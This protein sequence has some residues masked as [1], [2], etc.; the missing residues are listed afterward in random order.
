MDLKTIGLGLLSFSFVILYLIQKYDYSKLNERLYKQDARYQGELK[1]LEDTHQL[2]IKEIEDEKKIIVKEVAVK[3]KEMIETVT[4]KLESAEYYQK[5]NDENRTYHLEKLKGLKDQV[6]QCFEI[7]IKEAD[8]ALSKNDYRIAELF[9]RACL[10]LRPE[11]EALL[12][13][14][15]RIEVFRVVNKYGMAFLN[16]PKGEFKMGSIASEKMRSTDEALHKVT[17]TTNFYMMETEVTQ[18]QW[19]AVMNSPKGELR[20]LKDIVTPSLEK[21]L[22]LPV[23]NVSY[24]DVNNFIIKLNQMGV[25]QYRLPTEAEWEYAARANEKGAFGDN[26]TPHATAWFSQNSSRHSHIVRT[27]FPNSFGLYDMLG[28]VSEW[29]SDYYSSYGSSGATT[30]EPSEGVVVPTAPAAVDPKVTENSG[31]RVFRGGSFNDAESACR[32]SNRNKA[33]DDLNT[34]HL[35]FRLVYHQ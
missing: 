22:S 9:C 30:V 34:A 12:R 32:I 19:D 2:K 28:N 20:E 8:N 15:K 17:L 35:G 29:I 6:R 31:F 7:F 5:L 23:E 27:K 24:N 4:G 13:L 16:I 1:R 18:E 21:G 26:E 3:K 33:K 10:I 11:E 14:K 25:G